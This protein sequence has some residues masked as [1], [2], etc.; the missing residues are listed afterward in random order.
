MNY[1]Y[2]KDLFNVN[3]VFSST[4]RLWKH[5]AKNTYYISYDHREIIKPVVDNSYMLLSDKPNTNLSHYRDNLSLD[6]KQLSSLDFLNGR[7]EYNHSY[8][9]LN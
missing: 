8:W 7:V 4:V 3:P 5:L 9:K 1:E 2:V 6:A